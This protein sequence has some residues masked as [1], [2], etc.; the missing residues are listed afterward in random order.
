[1]LAAVDA[2]GPGEVIVDDAADVVDVT[3][4]ARSE[5]PPIR[6]A[7][8]TPSSEM[9]TSSASGQTSGATAASKN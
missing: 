9:T 2:R 3:V 1:M 5:R 6:I 8:S 7:P 4:I